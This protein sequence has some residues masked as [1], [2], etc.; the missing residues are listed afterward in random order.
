MV[1]VGGS[2]V[3]FG[4]S[5]TPLLLGIGGGGVSAAGG[6]VS[7]SIGGF[8]SSKSGSLDSIKLTSN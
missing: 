2:V 4:T 5:S 6:V 3:D 8:G 1:V 7:S